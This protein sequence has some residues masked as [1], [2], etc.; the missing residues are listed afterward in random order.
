MT[1]PPLFA[2]LSA[3]ALTQFRREKRGKSDTGTKGLLVC[4]ELLT[5]S[6]RERE[7]DDGRQDILAQKRRKQHLPAAGEAGVPVSTQQLSLGCEAEASAAVDGRPRREAR[8]SS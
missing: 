3:H 7:R 5:V 6:R 1:D 8:D 2:G 4:E